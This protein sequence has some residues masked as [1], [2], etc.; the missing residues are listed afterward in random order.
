MVGKPEI[1]KPYRVNWRNIAIALKTCNCLISTIDFRVVRDSIA[2]LWA[3]M[4][5]KHREFREQIHRWIDLI[6]SDDWYES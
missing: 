6:S 2:H 1:I 3:S 5:S 4:P